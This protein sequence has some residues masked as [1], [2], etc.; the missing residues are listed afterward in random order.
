MKRLALVI[1]AGLMLA[2]ASQ[3]SAA[4]EFSGKDRS[5]LSVR[6]G[7]S[8]LGYGGDVGYRLNEAF[9]VSATFGMADYSFDKSYDG[10]KVDGKF[11]L[12][13]VGAFID[14]YP[15]DGAFNVSLGG[16]WS[17][18][19]FKGLAKGVEFGGV[20]TDVALKVSQ[21]Q[22]FAPVAAVGWDFQLGDHGS[23]STDFGA[24]FG[25]GFKVDAT[26]SSGTV[27]QADINAEIAS[28]RK[29]ANDLKI[30]PYVKLTV[31]FKF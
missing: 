3:A 5:G 9:G 18:H 13:G 1:G 8:T 17:D 11:D 23:I 24:I 12:G 31:G 30:V 27:S 15:F 20:E 22:K 10:Y 2:G 25:K 16:V 26:E 14:I 7:A 6:A 21:K 4:E 19:S 28:F 29:D